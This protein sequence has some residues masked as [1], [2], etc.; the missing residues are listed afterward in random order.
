MKSARQNVILEIITSTEIETQNQLMAELLKH[1]VKS[2]QATLSRDI[3]ELRLVKELSTSGRYRYAAAAQDDAVEHSGRLRKIFKESVMSCDTAMNLIVI[4]TLP[5][6]AMAASSALDDME[7]AALLGTVAGDDT[8][9]MAM[10]DIESA[11]HLCEEIK[12]LF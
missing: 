9:F 1:G 11:R 3:K 8:L 4:K 2:T 10:R 7:I 12:S 6:L 5:G